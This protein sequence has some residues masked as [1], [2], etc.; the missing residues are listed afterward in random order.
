MASVRR[1]NTQS[2]I[3]KRHL[4]DREL[5]ITGAEYCLETGSVKFFQEQ[6]RRE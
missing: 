3:L 1:L 2:A 4:D 5:I 6:A